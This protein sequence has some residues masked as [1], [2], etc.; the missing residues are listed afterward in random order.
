M[1]WDPQEAFN[2]GGK[3]DVAGAMACLEE[4]RIHEILQAF[5]HTVAGIALLCLEVYQC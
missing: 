4:E 2:A 3:Q 5:S 1:A